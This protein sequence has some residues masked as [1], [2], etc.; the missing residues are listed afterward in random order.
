[1]TLETNRRRALALLGAGVLGTSVSSCGH[2]RVGTPPATGDGATTTH[3]SL[4]LT[5]AEGNALSL[6]ALRRIQSNGKGEVGYDD[7]L[8]DATTLEAIAIGPLYQ[9]EDG[10]IGI[11]VPTGRACTLTMSWPTSHGYSALMADLPA[12]GEHDLLEVAARTL[13]NRQAERYQ[14]AA[15]QGIKGA[16]EAATLRASAQQFLDACT[17]AQSWADRGRLANSALESASGA[18]IALDRALVAQAPQDAIIGVTFTR[19]PTTAEIT[20]ALAPGGPGGGKR[21]VSARLVIGD[22]HDAQEMAGW[23]TAVDSLHAQ[24]GLALAQICD[25]LDM[26]A[27]DDTAWDTRV[28][29]LIRAL[30]DVDTWEIG[31]EIGGDWLGAGAVAKAQRAA[32][33][34][35]ERTSA[36]TVLTLY[37]QLGQADPAFSLF[38]YV[39]KE[40]T[41]PIKDL[42]DVVGLSVYPQLHPLGTAAD[43]VLS[44]LDAAFLTSRIAVTEL[45][46][47]GQDL[48]SGPWWFGSASDPVVARTAVA[49]HVTG[50]AL[51]RADAWG[52]PFWWYYLEDQ[53]GTPGGQ[54]APALAAASNGF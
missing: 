4:H 19:V 15:A 12:S 49:E 46:Y 45:G 32:K 3:L 17:T 18:Q 42:V 31:N 50:A 47:G 29:T 30:P 16:D 51:G 27:L 33:A 38:S 2:G 22:P 6:E 25:S 21:K 7:A 23:R 20:A 10:A 48:N 35:R 43:R 40:V 1:M 52:A 5:D 54:V 11:D 41:R 24:G 53:I 13:H 26:A 14:Q 8:L 9:D 37:Y 39:T 36:T 44:T 34:V 28:D